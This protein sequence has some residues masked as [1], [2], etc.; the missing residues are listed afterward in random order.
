MQGRKLKHPWAAST[1]VGAAAEG[2]GLVFGQIREMRI[3][4]NHLIGR[5]LAGALVASALVVAAAETASAQA[6]AAS[7]AAASAEPRDPAPPLPAELLKDKTRIT[8]GTALWKENCAHCHGSKSYPGKAPKL[9]P[10]RYKPDFVWDRI[11]NGFKDMP[12]W[13]ELYTPEQVIAL[14]AYVLSDEFWP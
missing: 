14:V 12:A 7:P 2:E 13:K 10:H 6:P 8:E 3:M 1:V 11:H 5:G 4:N 9:T